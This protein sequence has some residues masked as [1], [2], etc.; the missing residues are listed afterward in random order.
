MGLF[1]GSKSS[2]VVNETYQSY[3][4]RVGV[5]GEGIIAQGS[6]SSYNYVNEL[7]DT[8]GTIISSIADIA[9]VAIQAGGSALDTANAS[10]QQSIK[11]VADL[12]L[13]EQLGADSQFKPILIAGIA[14]VALIGIVY[15]W[16]K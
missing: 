8:V 13:A 9:K 4:Q 2:T 12:K 15:F 6:G 16:K 1:G 5:E 10:T 14:A 11:S 3:D 7:P